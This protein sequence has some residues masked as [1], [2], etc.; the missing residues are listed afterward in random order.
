MTYR[1]LSFLPI[2]DWLAAQPPRHW[3]HRRR[4]V[5]RRPNEPDDIEARYR[6]YIIGALD[7]YALRTLNLS[8]GPDDDEDW[9]DVLATLSRDL[10]RHA[11]AAFERAGMRVLPNGRKRRQLW[12]GILSDEWLQSI[13]ADAARWSADRWNLEEEHRAREAAAR[14]G[15]RS[16]RPKVYTPADLVPGSI[17]AQA[18]ALGCSR[19]TIARLR[20]QQKESVRA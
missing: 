2:R 16:K 3:D 6:S 1:R 17:K 7:S 12:D 8:W 20:T 11:L 19:R 10:Y 15:R 13:A 4:I 14:G 18:E 9:D 5:V